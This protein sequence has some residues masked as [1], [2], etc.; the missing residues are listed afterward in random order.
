VSA[1]N[2]V[3]Q[4]I[5]DLRYHWPSQVEICVAADLLETQQAMLA[6]KDGEIERL[7]RLVNRLDED[8]TR[9]DAY[10][11]SVCEA[12][13]RAEFVD[14]KKVVLADKRSSPSQQQGEYFGVRVVRQDG[15]SKVCLCIGH[16]RFPIGDSF[17][18][19]TQAKRFASRIY[20]AALYSTQ[21]KEEGK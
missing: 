13:A 18:D 2:A 14:T 7:Q 3:Q 12:M 19:R 15:W 20:N 10:W 1:T 16:E 8:S 17:F 11:Q 5:A 9:S 6:E 21:R 4:V